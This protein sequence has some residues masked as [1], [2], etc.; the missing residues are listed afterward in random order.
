MGSTEDWWYSERL[1]EIREEERIRKE[2]ENSEDL[3]KMV[4]EMKK[5]RKKMPENEEKG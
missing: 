4:E 5:N 2:K 1:P 3:I